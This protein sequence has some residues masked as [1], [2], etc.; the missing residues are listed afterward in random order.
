MRFEDVG[1]WDEDHDV[2]VVGFGAAGG[3]AAIEAHDAGADVVLLEKMGFPGGL[4]AISAGGIRVSDDAEG[5]FEYL[6]CTC[7]G[8]TPDDLLRDLAEAMVELPEYIRGLAEVNGA[9]VRV[10][11]AV[12]NYPFP[13]YISLGYCEVSEVPELEDGRRYYATSATTNGTR[14][15]KVLEDNIAR[16]EIP[17]R[18][19]T[20]AKELITDRSGQICG[21]IV[22]RNGRTISIQS[23][24]A[25]ILTCGGFEN[26][27]DMQ[28][29]YLQMGDVRPT[30]FR[31]N[32]GDGIAM[33][34][35]V[36][37]DLWHMWHVHG[38][39]GLHDPSNE[40]P[41]AFFHKA[42]PMWTPGHTG[43]VSN[44]GIEETAETGKPRKTLAKLAWILVDRDGR[45]F[46]NE[47][48]PYPGDTGL[49]PFDLFDPLKQ[50]FARR[51]AYMIFDENGRKMYPMGYAAWNDD[52]ASYTWS[53]DNLDEIDRGIFRR[54]DSLEDLAEGIGVSV[55]Q[56]RAT[57]EDWNACVGD[58]KDSRY[59]RRA[60]TMVR[61]DNPPFYYGEVGPV[62]INTQG[63]PRHSR[64]QQVLSPF[65]KPISRL[66]AAGELGSVFGYLYMGGGNLAECIAGGRTAG[67]EAA[68]L[69]PIAQ[70]HENTSQLV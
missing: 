66:Y 24:R 10:T 25:V 43:S 5:A 51:P 45:R 65:D 36:G 34:Q 20:A 54:A 15:L 47:Y 58:G 18:Y 52:Q 69:E 68:A 31:G 63:G 28:R 67:R 44:L 2:I 27:A 16:R 13:G 64:L 17:V 56:I 21:L 48:P 70:E 57:V 53:K 12:G 35:A 60:E 3:V 30:S 1:K 8:R 22:E 19:Q 6:K 37:A 49:R 29:Q 42:I 38:P 26:N 32:T 23:R 50:D 14:L 9:T 62:V 46:M 61:I 4:S 39:Y 11:P 59:G 40:Y 55:E 7:G 33:A 41:F